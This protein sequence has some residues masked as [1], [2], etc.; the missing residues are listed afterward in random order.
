MELS[1]KQRIL[2][3]ALVMF[4]SNGYNGTNLR[5]LASNLGLSKSALYRHYDSKEQIFNELVLTTEEYYHKNFGSFDNIKCPNSTD[6]LI[7]MSLARLSFTLHDEK[8][9][10]VRKMLTIEQFRN[11][12]IS[13]L[14]TLHFTTGVEEMHKV[15]FT[16]MIEK[17]I[18]NSYDPSLLAMEFSAPVS[19]LIQLVDREPHKEQMAMDKIKHYLEHFVKVYGVN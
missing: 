6:E 5:D 12:K 19:A 2:N 18:I 16:E 13:K 3:E 8:I 11:E 17:G 10:L 1:T 15:I 9:K 14:A 4:A 7:E